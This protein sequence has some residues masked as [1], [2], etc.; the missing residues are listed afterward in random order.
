MLYNLQNNPRENMDVS[1]QYPEITN[2]LK[3]LA[4][5]WRSA[6]PKLND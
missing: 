4:L 1:D 6:L 3:A 2:E 5:S